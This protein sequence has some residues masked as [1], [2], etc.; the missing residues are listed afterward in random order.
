M[1]IW[2][3]T[4]QHDGQQAGQTRTQGGFRHFLW[5]EKTTPEKSVMDGLEEAL[6][7]L[8]R[9]CIAGV[10]A[11]EEE[12]EVDRYY[13]LLSHSLKSCDIPPS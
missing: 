7:E 13:V 12:D 3:A 9:G 10:K 4:L 6:K 5:C 2:S 11:S 1:N 8:L